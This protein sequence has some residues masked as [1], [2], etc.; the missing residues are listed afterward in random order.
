MG[1][2]FDANARTWTIARSAE[3]SETGAVAGSG[4]GALT[5]KTARKT[6]PIATSHAPIETE[7]AGRTS[8][9]ETD[10]MVA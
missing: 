4:F 5:A 1:C 10:W 8:F 7:T 2:G 6:R 3:K 9:E